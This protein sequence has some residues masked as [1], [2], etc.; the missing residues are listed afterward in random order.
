MLLGGYNYEV[1]SVVTK[2]KKSVVCDKNIQKEYVS[3]KVKYSKKY[4]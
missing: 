2:K 1:Q 4:L 3:Y